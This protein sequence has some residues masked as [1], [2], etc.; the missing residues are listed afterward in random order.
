MMNKQRTSNARHWK[1][2]T[3]LP[4]LALL[5]LFCGRKGNNA[6][7][8]QGKQFN[9]LDTT[10]S[11]KRLI[12][13]DTTQYSPSFIKGLKEGLKE[14]FKDGSV[15]YE[16]ISVSNDSLIDKYRFKNSSRDTVFIYK[17]T[18]PTNLELNKEIVFTTKNK[19]KSFTLILKRTNYTNIEYQLKKE[20]ET[21]K[22]G[23][24]ILGSSFYF[25]AEMDHDQNGKE[26]ASRQYL[27]SDW[28]IIKVEIYQARI[29]S[30]CYCVDQ[31]TQKF[32]TLSN[33]LRE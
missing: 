10:I 8:V 19:D 17:Y 24:A 23:I 6:P 3:F 18:I 22:S 11:G 14:G 9:R 29:A 16:T 5:L 2:V 28:T 27:D 26:T 13:K 4:L 20:R 33:F 32:E 1:V 25:G 7:V 15:G 21:I 30:I 12:V 31:K